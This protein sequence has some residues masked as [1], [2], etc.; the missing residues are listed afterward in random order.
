M[1]IYDA[2][3]AANNKPL[4]Q[5]PVLGIALYLAATILI[6]VM[7]AFVKKATEYH[8]PI[9]AVF[10]RGIVA[11]A[12]LLGYATFKG[13]FDLYKTTRIKSHLGRAIAGNIGVTMVF[14]SY[15]LMP[16]A[17]ATAMLFAAPL[18]V[19]VFSALLLKEYV[20][21]YRWA[22]VATGFIGVLLIAHPSGADYPHY[23]IAVVLTAACSTAAVQ[24]FLREL[25][26]T[27]DAL[28]TVFYFLAF[29]ITFSG[30]YM[31]FKGHAPDP[32]AV[33]PLLC[34]G[35]ASG[36]QLI[37][38]TQAFRLAEASLLSPFSYSSIIW[39]TMAGWLFWGSL[40]TA[41]V[42]AGTIVVI[43]SNLFILWRERRATAHAA[44]ARTA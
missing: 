7:N 41:T 4:T 21:P 34:A 18:I 31:V 36:I 39:A 44:S 2:E 14:W 8:T 13:R 3:T 16:M 43:S 32:H 40:P 26:K 1:S 10:Y 30:I 6:V 17:D 5:K 22:A 33:I 25:G 27:E 24:I 9:E 37:I 35:V 28:T 11:M 38:K 23:A 29:G 20:G 15:S 19:T 42:I 12:L